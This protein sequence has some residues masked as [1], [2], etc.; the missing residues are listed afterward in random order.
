MEK[1]AAALRTSPDELLPQSPNLRGA[2]G[3]VEFRVDPE[4]PTLAW[5]RID[6]AVKT[7]TGAK[8]LGL[9]YLDSDSQSSTD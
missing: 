8:I 7:S 4:D 5:L 1:L 2:K 6:Q 3:T 9:L